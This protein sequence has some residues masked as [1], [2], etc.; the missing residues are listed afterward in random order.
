SIPC[1]LALAHVR[2]G[3]WNWNSSPS[4]STGPPARCRVSLR[5]SA[6]FAASL[7]SGFRDRRFASEGGTAPAMTAR[8][9]SRR[10]IGDSGQFRVEGRVLGRVVDDGR[11]G[12]HRL[13]PSVDGDRQ[14]LTLGDRGGGEEGGEVRLRVPV[15]RQEQRLRAEDGVRRTPQRERD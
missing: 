2:Y 15:D 10:L 7:V 12:V 11:E 13:R 1:R 9:P 3:A 6:M 8:K 14:R 5:P 4:N